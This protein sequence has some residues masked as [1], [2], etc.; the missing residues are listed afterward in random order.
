VETDESPK[1]SPQVVDT[2][3]HSLWMT[4]YAGS[5]PERAANPQ[6][7]ETLWMNTGE[8]RAEH[9]MTYVSRRLDRLPSIG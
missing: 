1:P 4:P 5:P 7:A 8:T 6:P 9:P 3:I 2:F